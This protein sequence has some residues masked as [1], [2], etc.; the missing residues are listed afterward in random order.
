MRMRKRDQGLGPEL[1][2]KQ[3]P[4]PQVDAKIVSGFSQ[5]SAARKGGGS[6][7][8]IGERSVSDETSQVSMPRS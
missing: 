3:R 2:G 7:T 6:E 5:G 8:A 4:A 1:G